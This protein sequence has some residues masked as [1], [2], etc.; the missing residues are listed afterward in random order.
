MKNIQSRCRE[1]GAKLDISTL[2]GTG[3]RFEILLK[4]IK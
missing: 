1:I 4:A 3:T 2:P